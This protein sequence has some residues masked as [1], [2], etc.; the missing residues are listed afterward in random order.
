MSDWSFAIPCRSKRER[1]DLLSI[2]ETTAVIPDRSEREVI[3]NLL[4]HLSNNGS[5]TF[6]DVLAL[7]DS[8]SPDRRRQLLDR[9]R[10]EVGLEPTSYIDEQRDLAAAR[11]GDQPLPPSV[12][13]ARRRDLGGKAWQSCHAPGCE[14][15]PVDSQ[16]FQVPVRARRWFCPEHRHLAADGDLDDWEGPPLHFGL[17]GL[18]QVLTEV[19][20][21]FYAQIDHEREDEDAERERERERLAEG[22]AEARRKW[23]QNGM[24]DGVEIA[25]LPPSRV[26]R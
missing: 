5:R 1:L 3:T 15:V 7:L 26:E 13:T 2:R 9:A 4:E 12:A 14:A 22:D 21:D 16:G 10:I 17:A 19:D 11:R 23:E 20:E 18:E 24:D 6:G 25:G 8:A